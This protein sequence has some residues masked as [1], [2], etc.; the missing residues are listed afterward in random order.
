MPKLRKPLLSETASGKMDEGSVLTV[1]M[2][3]SLTPNP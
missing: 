3:Y 1:G 2:S